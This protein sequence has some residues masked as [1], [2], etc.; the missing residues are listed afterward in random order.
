MLLLDL[1]EVVLCLAFCLN[2]LFLPG[3]LSSICVRVH[4]R[5]MYPHTDGWHGVSALSLENVLHRPTSESGEYMC[6]HLASLAVF[7]LFVW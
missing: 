3:A 6:A 4:A 7:A 1:L 2:A 5:R